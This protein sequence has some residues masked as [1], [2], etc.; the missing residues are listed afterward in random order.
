MD[1]NDRAAIERL[2]TKLGEFERQAPPRDEEAE[3]FIGEC[4]RH[5]PSAPY[6][7]AQTVVAQEQALEQA[8]QRIAELEQQAA[9]PVARAPQ[10][11]FQSPWARPAG[12][13]QQRGGGFLAGAAQTAMGVAGGVLVANALMGMFGGGSADAAEPGGDAFDAGDDGFDG[14]FDDMD[15]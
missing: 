15:F 10:P 12:A 14:G 6:F 13:G 5:Q 4:I 9:D 2:F 11:G 8:Q 1:R 3:R 7:M